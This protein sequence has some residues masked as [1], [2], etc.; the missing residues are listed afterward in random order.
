M[1]VT[2]STIATYKCCWSGSASNFEC[3]WD[4]DIMMVVVNYD[5]IVKNEIIYVL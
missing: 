5:E 3:G 4:S 1:K 2:Y